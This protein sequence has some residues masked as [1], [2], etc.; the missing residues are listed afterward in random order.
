MPLDPRFALVPRSHDRAEDLAYCRR[1]LAGGSRSFSAAARLLPPRMRDAAT[2]VYAYCRRADD[3]ID[4][5]GAP[6]FAVRELWYQ[7]DRLY[8][9]RPTDD[10]I[11]RALAEVIERFDVPRA[12]FRALLDGFAWDATGRPIVDE[13]DLIAYAVRVAGTIGILM[14]ALMGARDAR[15]LARAC[16][17]GVAMQLTNIARDVG[18][19][20][21]RGRIYLPM[22][23]L[24]AEGCTT[25][26][27][28]GE[29]FDPAITRVV[30]RVLTRADELYLR[31]DAGIAALPP[32]SRVAIRAAAWIYADIGRLIRAR[33]CDSITSRAHTSWWRKSVLMWR[34]RRT[35]VPIDE[36]ALS[37]PPLP[38][39]A[40]LVAASARP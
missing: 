13:S 18:E 36:D 14:S 16:D 34:A 8:A 33:G 31:A 3:A 39:A 40:A 5:G 30:D 6:E 15:L 35:W 22:S 4:L 1:M 27:A 29:T 28:A 9:G 26:S 38:E 12:P 10:P 20:A 21:R 2:V 11:E 32:D 17:L 24:E 7:L 23:W 37:H 19:D 25:H